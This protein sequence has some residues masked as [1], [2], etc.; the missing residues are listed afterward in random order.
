M[1]RGCDTMKKF[2]KFALNKD[3]NRFHIITLDITGYD[4]LPGVG[5]CTP[6]CKFLN[7]EFFGNLKNILHDK[8]GPHYPRHDP[9]F[10]VSPHVIDIVE[11]ELSFHK[12]SSSKP[13]E[14]IRVSASG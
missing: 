12:A 7:Q 5:A 1:F 3:K 4:E 8:G 13:R 14:G 11:K 6:P 9:R 2:E 10:Q